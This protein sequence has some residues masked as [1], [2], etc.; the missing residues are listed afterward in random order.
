M[1]GLVELVGVGSSSGLFVVILRALFE[2][3]LI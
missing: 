2:L 1:L 3:F